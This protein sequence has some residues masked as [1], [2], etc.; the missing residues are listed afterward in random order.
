MADGHAVAVGRDNEQANAIQREE[1]TVEEHAHISVRN[2]RGNVRDHVG[3]SARA[4]GDRNPLLLR[5][6]HSRVVAGG[7]G[8]Q[9]EAGTPRL[10]QQGAFVGLDADLD[11]LLFRQGADKLVDPAHVDGNFAALLD[12]DRSQRL[13]QH[14]CV[15]ADHAQFP[16]VGGFQKH[17]AEHGDGAASVSGSGN[18][19][20]GRGEAFLGGGDLHVGYLLS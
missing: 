19:S 5:G 14:P 6:R 11:G 4:H 16:C 12:L 7:E 1:S 13:R 10:H 3:Q 2:R 9:T 15:R 20:E 8:G 17:R 18:E